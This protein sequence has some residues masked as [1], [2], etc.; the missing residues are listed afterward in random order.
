MPNKSPT[1][2]EIIYKLD[3]LFHQIP[4]SLLTH[5]F[6][7][8]GAGDWFIDGAKERGASNEDAKE[9]V[10]NY[11]E[12]TMLP[13]SDELL[14][15]VLMGYTFETILNESKDMF[16]EIQKIKEE[17]MGAIENTNNIIKLIHGCDTLEKL[18]ML[19]EL[20]ILNDSDSE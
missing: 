19:K 14:R 9:L 17:H 3:E 10:K 12:E 20:P 4:V 8:S 13:K 15:I 16:S 18:N 5:S 7:K 11:F 2:K 6:I 1:K